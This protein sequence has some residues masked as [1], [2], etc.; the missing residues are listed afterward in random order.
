MR[1]RRRRTRVVGAFPDGQFVR[2]PSSKR[3]P[4]AFPVRRVLWCTPRI[5]RCPSKTKDICKSPRR[6][7]EDSRIRLVMLPEVG[8]VE[9]RTPHGE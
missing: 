3:E 5:Y 7:C 8:K 9:L 2:V 1:E 6:F 4:Q